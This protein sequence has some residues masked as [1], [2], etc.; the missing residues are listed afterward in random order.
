MPRR[1][2]S[3]TLPPV[4]PPDQ[5]E[6]SALTQRLA[7]LAEAGGILGEAE[8]ELLATFAWDLGRTLDDA[9]GMVERL[10]SASRIVANA[11][12]RRAASSR[13]LQAGRLQVHAARVHEVY[14]RCHQQGCHQQGC[15][16]PGQQQAAR[17][18]QDS[19]T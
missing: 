18:A 9:D 15:Q 19:E 4:T 14:Q 2:S 13:L 6:L 11:D 1:R 3:W 12:G 10:I 17:T 16:Q 5:G 8:P 7:D